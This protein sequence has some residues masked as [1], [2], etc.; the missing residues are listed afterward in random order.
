M[1]GTTDDLL[2]PDVV[3]DPHAHFARLRAED[4]VHWS[5]RHRAF[6]LTRY[7]DVSTALRDPVLSADRLASPGHEA[8]PGPAVRTLSRWLVFND[9]PDHTRL[10]R[11]V[12][13]AFTARVVESLRAHVS[14]L[15]D[16]LLDDVEEAGGGDLVARFAYPLPAMV[17]AELLGAPPEDRDRF[18]AWSDD[19]GTV[20]FG[21][22]GSPDRYARAERGLAEFSD[23]FAALVAAAEERRREGSGGDGLLSTLVAARDRDDALSADEVVATAILL[24]FAGH[25]TTTSLLANG[26]L[27]LLRFPDQLA[28]LRKDPGLAPSAVEELLRYDGPAT[29]VVRRAAADHERR[30]RRIPAGSR[31]FLAVAAANR[32][33]ERFADPDRLDLARRDNAHLGFGTGIHLCLGAPLARLEGQV[34]LPA[35]LARFPDLRLAT[36]RLEWH[37]A[38]LS[39]S[40]T[41]LPVA[42]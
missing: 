17:I 32:D 35:L 12:N 24:L 42:V 33:P 20:V 2:A 7:D 8:E 3:A 25:E 6:V 23:Y 31:V 4:P 19:V 36:D 10:R 30:G 9:P 29:I 40:L 22:V 38:L 27:A 14:A 28:R 37:P 11:L 16:G 15:V 18:R 39:R 34:A 26:T 21:A 41:A 5:E 13:R 1:A